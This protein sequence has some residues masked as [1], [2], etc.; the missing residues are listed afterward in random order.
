MEKMIDRKKYLRQ[1]MLINTKNYSRFIVKYV[2]TNLNEVGSYEMLLDE[3]GISERIFDICLKKVSKEDKSLHN[4]FV[5]A[6]LKYQEKVNESI[7]E[8]INN[9]IIGI[10]SGFF[11][12]GKEFSILELIKRLP[13]KGTDRPIK[14]LH[15]FVLT[16]MPE[17]RPLL[18]FLGRNNLITNGCAKN[19]DKYWFKQVIGSKYTINGREVT[20]EE[21]NMLITYMIHNQIPMYSKMF[22]YVRKLYL[23]GELD[24]YQGPILKEDTPLQRVLSKEDK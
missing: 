7:K 24:L 20:P 6:K 17:G 21:N 8:E 19:D 13:F 22:M 14:E 9:L 18:D 5:A 11:E 1:K 2:T 12:D 10:N 3:L 15:K 23:N 16:I 4:D